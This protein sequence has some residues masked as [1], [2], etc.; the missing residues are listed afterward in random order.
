[1]PGIT[2]DVLKYRGTH[3]VPTEIQDTPENWDSKYQKLVNACGIEE[4]L[5]EIMTISKKVL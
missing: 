3:D 1:M 2:K 4:T 5:E